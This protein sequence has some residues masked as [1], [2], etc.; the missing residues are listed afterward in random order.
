MGFQLGTAR[1][2]LGRS[3]AQHGDAVRYHT[4]AERTQPHGPLVPVNATL[5]TEQ[6]SA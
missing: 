1:S 4:W 2:I 5:W 3:H 6:P